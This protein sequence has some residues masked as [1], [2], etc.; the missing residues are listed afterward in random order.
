MKTKN[1]QSLDEGEMFFET[2]GCG[3]SQQFY[4]ASEKDQQR[5]RNPPSSR[6]ASVGHHS[7]IQGS[8]KKNGAENSGFRV[9]IT[10]A[11]VD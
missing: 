1:E 4:C 2:F 9:I 8:K 11:S 6:G 10:R 7:G 5:L 3:K